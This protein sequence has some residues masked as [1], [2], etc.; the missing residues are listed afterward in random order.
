VTSD[1]I[2]DRTLTKNNVRSFVLKIDLI[3][4]KNLHLNKV[5]EKLSAHFDRTEKRLVSNFIVNFTNADSKISQDNTYDYVLTSESR[6]I[7]MT[8]S[9]T[10]SAFWLETSSYKNNTVYKEIIKQTIDIIK[11]CSD[12][13]ESKRIGL[14]YVNEFECKQ[15]NDIKRIFDKRLSTIVK[16]M[17]SSD[18]LIRT[19]GME[20]YNTEDQNF[21]RLQ[22]GIPNKFYPSKLAMYDLLLDI[23]SYSSTTNNINDWEQLIST[24]NHSAYNIF[25]TTLNE[26][27][28]DKLK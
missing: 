1:S 9:D 26:K 17:L 23:D 18:N 25:K 13:V 21:L 6:N 19:I 2:E 10:Q 12:D 4:N 11:D 15:Q 27:F 28:L 24:L 22:Y 3:K 8:F 5:V 7:S 20:E 16:N 14:R